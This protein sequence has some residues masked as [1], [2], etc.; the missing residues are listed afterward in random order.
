MILAAGKGTRVQPLTHDMPKPMI[1]ILGKPV[2]EY[3]IEHLARHGIHEIMVN[4]SYLHEQIENYFGDG[5]RFGVEIGYSFEGDLR[6][7]EVV[8]QPIGS[9]GGVRKIQDFGG[10]FDTT[11][12]V[13]CGDA[14][15]DLDIGAALAEHRQQRAEAS[16]IA[17]E[18]PWEAVSDYGVV[19]TDDHGRISSFQEKPEREEARSNW[20]ST[21]IYIFE[22]TVIGRIPTRTFYDI[23][24]QL[25]PDLVSS[26]A[27][28]Y[29][30]RQRF[31]WIDIGKVSDYWTVCQ[32]VMQGE[33]AGMRMPGSQS[34]VG[35]WEGLNVRVDASRDALAG[36]VHI[37]SGS[38]I[39]QG[40]RVTGPT[41]IGHGCVIEAGAHVSRCVLFPYTRVS[42]GAVFE[43]AILSGNYCVDRHGQ[44]RELNEGAWGDSRAR[45]D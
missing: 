37:G 7:G 40:A 34:R 16:V 15:I 9:A 27:P 39:E 8:P 41:W 43:D 14:L 3:L 30:Q 26:R 32:R 4:V 12:L 20:A 21:G 38:H 2:M 44:I 42:A 17:S 25:F 36:P 10:F 31:N 5:S 35:I 24:S 22:P 23:G 28:F 29:A 1:P 19:V 6:G 13:L 18:V 11:T 45:R 33:V